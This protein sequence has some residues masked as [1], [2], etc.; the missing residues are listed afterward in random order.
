MRPKNNYLHM[1]SYEHQYSCVVCRLDVATKIVTALFFNISGSFPIHGLTLN[2]FE[3]LEKSSLHQGP[4][5]NSVCIY[6]PKAGTSTK[7]SGGGWMIL[8]M[9]WGVG[10]KKNSDII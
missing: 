5:F 1:Y 6:I 3:R 9:R 4:Y 8:Q 7:L 10:E 2:G